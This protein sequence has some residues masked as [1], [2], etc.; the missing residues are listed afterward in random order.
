MR[1]SLLL[2]FPDP[3]PLTG[4]ECPPG[5][6]GPLRAAPTALFLGAGPRRARSAGR[7]DSAEGP[8]RGAWLASSS[9]DCVPGLLLPHLPGSP[10]TPPC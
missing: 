7:V 9:P 1:W 5:F 2:L 3:C 6:A 10:G 4:L 8:L